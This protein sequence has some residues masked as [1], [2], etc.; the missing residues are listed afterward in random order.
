MR[1]YQKLLSFL[2]AFVMLFTCALP[3]SA[4]ANKSSSNP[5]AIYPHR[6]DPSKV[7]VFK[8]FMD[9][10]NCGEY[11]NRFFEKDKTVE[12]ALKYIQEV[13]AL[14]R[15]IPKIAVLVGCQEGGHDYQWPSWNNY[16]NPNIKREED[17][18]AQT[19]LRWL[20]EEA[21]KYH[22]N[23]T[24][25]MNITDANKTNKEAWNT[26]L[27]N[28]WVARWPEAT[29][30]EGINTPDEDLQS[31]GE[32][33]VHDAVTGENYYTHVTNIAK[34]WEDGEL[35]RKIDEFLEMFPFVK[36][37][38]MLYFDQ[39]ARWRDSLNYIHMKSSSRP[40]G[41]SVPI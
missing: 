35:R 15:G 12:D 41:M 28:G 9:G 18:D 23:I 39:T 19:S 40:G 6:I 13:D 37:T 26:A 1:K 4:A 3:V 30:E 22:T 38:K 20:A 21:K 33:H 14:T 5:A 17:S 10:R 29:G 2:M 8:I 36:E 11:P 25:H 16:N 7:W 32:I 24:F 34:M 31:T 27:E